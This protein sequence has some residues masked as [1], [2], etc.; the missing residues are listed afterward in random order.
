MRYVLAYVI[1]GVA[2]LS[3]ANWLWYPAPDLHGAALGLLMGAIF[4]AGA[5]TAMALVATATARH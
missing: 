1:G 3:L 5:A 2:S 4:I